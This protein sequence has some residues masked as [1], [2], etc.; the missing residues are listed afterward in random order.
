MLFQF[1]LASAPKNENVI[2]LVSIALASGEA[3]L[4]LEGLLLGLLLGLVLGLS[5]GL[6]L[7]LLLFEFEQPLSINA[8]VSVNNESFFV[9]LDFIELPP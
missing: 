2:G 3:E 7:L 9:V 6:L 8:P 5:L 4:V 1:G